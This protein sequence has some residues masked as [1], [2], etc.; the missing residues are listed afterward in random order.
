MVTKEE[1]LGAKQQQLHQ[2]EDLDGQHPS[3]DIKIQKI[4]IQIIEIR[5]EIT[6]E[7]LEKAG[8]PEEKK[9]L[10]DEK[11][12]LQ[13]DKQQDKELLISLQKKEN[14]L[15]Q[16]QSNTTQGTSLMHS[17]RCL[18]SPS[19]SAHAPAPLHGSVFCWLAY[20]L[21]LHYSLT[22]LIPY[23]P[24]LPYSLIDQNSFPLSALFLPH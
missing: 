6:S 22:L 8:T 11:K 17:C 15:L 21:C 20:T 3:D 9:Q 2:L 19:A 13:D 10:Q 7:R 23:S 12:Q 1:R 4:K 14:L 18:A 5:I 16:H 24:S